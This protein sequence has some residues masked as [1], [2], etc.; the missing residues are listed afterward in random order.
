M[1][2]P[3]DVIT[4]SIKRCDIVS[5]KWLLQNINAR[6]NMFHIGTNFDQVWNLRSRS[7]I[8]K[9]YSQPLHHLPL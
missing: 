6:I 7:K 2:S 5:L 9:L 4:E 8:K 3:V 1:V